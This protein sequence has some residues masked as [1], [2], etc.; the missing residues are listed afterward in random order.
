MYLEVPLALGAKMYF[1]SVKSVKL[2]RIELYEQTILIVR[3]KVNKTKL[4]AGIFSSCK[5]H[6]NEST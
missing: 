5:L 3:N 6:F 1:I 4:N 2:M